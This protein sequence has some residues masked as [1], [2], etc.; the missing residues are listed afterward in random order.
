M[1]QAHSSGRRAKRARRA[2]TKNLRAARILRTKQFN[3]YM[4]D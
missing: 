1:L 3:S 2:E 4:S